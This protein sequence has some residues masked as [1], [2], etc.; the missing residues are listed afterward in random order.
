VINKNLRGPLRRIAKRLLLGVPPHISRNFLQIDDAGLRSIEASIREHYHTEWRGESHYSKISYEHDLNAHLYKRLDSDRREIIPWIDSARTLKDRRILEVGCGTG[1]STVALAEQGARVTAIDIDEGALMVA[2]RRASVFGVEAEFQSLNAQEISRAFT[3]STFDV[4]IFFAC[5]E[6][7]T[8]AERLASLSSAWSMLPA[9]GLLI[10]V[11]TP[12]R[13]WYMDDHTSQ[14]PFFHWLPNDL[15][16][17]YA[18]FSQREN[19]REL[20]DDYDPASKEHFLRR[21]RGM[22]FHEV[23][24]AIGPTKDLSVISSLSTYQGLTYKLRRSHLDRQYKSLLQ[25]IY[26]GVHEGFFDDMLYLIVKR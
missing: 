22:S 18:K 3:G 13:L 21:G 23:D 16:F 2:K 10:I 24:L 1:S 4:I 15:A 12:N 25:R 6:H 11:E 26:P 7:M 5:L 19:F 9:D 14:L 20:Y 8:V 17:A